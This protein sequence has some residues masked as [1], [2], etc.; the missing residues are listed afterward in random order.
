M[1]E[2]LLKQILDEI[3]GLREDIN[4]FMSDDDDEECT[5]GCAEDEEC[6]CGEEHEEHHHEECGCGEDHDHEPSAEEL[7]AK[8][9]WGD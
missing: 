4:D 1:S 7:D 9:N 6:T 5:C 8:V 2:E 3:K